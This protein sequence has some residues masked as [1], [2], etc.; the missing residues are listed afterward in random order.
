MKVEIS[1]RD[2]DVKICIFIF[3]DEFCYN[4]LFVIIEYGCGIWVIM[5]YFNII[6]LIFVIF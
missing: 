2:L 6:F 4:I 3:Y 1:L 5:I